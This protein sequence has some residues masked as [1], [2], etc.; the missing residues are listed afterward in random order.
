M[1]YFSP[2]SAQT[3]QNCPK[4]GKKLDIRRSCTEVFMYCPECR[5]EFPLRDFIGKSDKA[6]EDFLENVYLDRI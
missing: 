6:M 3:T 4:C 2:R 5:K 1:S